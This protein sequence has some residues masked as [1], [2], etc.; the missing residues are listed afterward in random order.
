[1]ELAAGRLSRG[2]IRRHVGAVLAM[3]RP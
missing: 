1:V 3:A 2:G